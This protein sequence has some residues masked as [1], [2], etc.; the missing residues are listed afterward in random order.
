MTNGLHSVRGIRIRPRNEKDPAAKAICV[1]IYASSN[2]PHT[3]KPSSGCA[4]TSLALG[5][6][7]DDGNACSG[8]DRCAMQQGAAT[9]VASAQLGCDDSN[10]CTT[11]SCTGTSCGHAPLA[12]GAPCSDGNACTT[13]DSCQTPS[14]TLVCTASGVVSC[15]DGNP[16]TPD[17]CNGSVGCVVSTGSCDDSNPCTSDACGGQGCSHAYTPGLCAHLP[18]NFAEPFD[19]GDTQWAFTP[20]IAGATGQTKALWAVDTTPSPPM[21]KSSGCTLNF[22]DGTGTGGHNSGAAVSSG[23]WD[24]TGKTKL[25]LTLQSWFD[26]RT[27]PA[28]DLRIIEASADGFATTPVAVTLDNTGPIQNA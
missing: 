28:T 23:S 10:P 17:A 25:T 22:N 9:C 20:A 8:P 26:L 6:Y 24:A 15:S 11:D 13:G 14:G 7:C 19:C 12:A 2:D 3:C 4:H 5:T 1:L 16:C 27:A 21:P 18:L